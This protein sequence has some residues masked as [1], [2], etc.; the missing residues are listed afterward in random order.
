MKLGEVLEAAKM[1]SKGLLSED[2]FK[3]CIFEWM[4]QDESII[5]NLLQVLQAERKEKKELL[6]NTN[7]ELSRAL[8][9]LQTDLEKPFVIGK[10][11]EHYLKWQHRIKCCF[12]IKGLP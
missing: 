10:I 12:N 3:M 6:L 5:P 11:K 7:L 9:T 8:V 1:C 4:A 2:A